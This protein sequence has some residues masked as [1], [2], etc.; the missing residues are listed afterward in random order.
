M[1]QLG[2]RIAAPLFLLLLTA[3]FFWR[4]T[5]SPEYTWLEGDDIAFTGRPWL[6]MQAREIHAGRFPLW[7][8]YEWGGQSVIGQVQPGITNPL[9]WILFA[10]PLREGHLPIGVLHWYWVLIRWLA[11]LACYALCRELK[12]GVAA[13]ALGASIY[14]LTGLIGHTD[15]PYLVMPAI[16]LPVALLGFTRMFRGE[17]PRSGAALCGLAMGMA[18]L[19]GHHQIPVDFT[20]VL[21]ALWLWFL[22][23]RGRQRE[24][25]I[26]AGVFAAIWLLVGAFQTLPALEYGRHSV[27]WANA[28]EPLRWQDKVPWSVHETYSFDW[29]LF[30]G[31]VMPRLRSFYMNPFVGFTAAAL[32]LSGL[33]LVRRSRDARL[34]AAVTLGGLVLALG[35]NTPV[36]RPLYDWVPL[37]E[38]ARTPAMAIV[39]AQLG[40]AALAAMA[41]QAWTAKRLAIG[42]IA[43]A[44]AVAEM[45]NAAPHFARFDRPDS[46]VKMMR[47]QSDI[48]GFLRKQPGWFRVRASEE[49]VPYNLG[50]FFGIE[51]FGGYVASMPENILKAQGRVEAARWFGIQYRIGRTPANTAE[52]EVFQSRT[53]LKVYRDPRIAEPVWFAHEAAC[54]AP[55]RFRVERRWPGGMDLQVSLPCPGEVIVGDPYFKGWKAWVDGRPAKISES[56]HIVRAVRVEAGNHR[57]EYRYRP[58]LVYWGGIASLLGVALAVWVWR[59]ESSRMQSCGVR[60]HTKSAPPV[61]GEF[62]R[63]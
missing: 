29:R 27:R 11:T 31:L 1:K 19:G 48:A 13:S 39:I 18:F 4:L 44:L 37:V 20:L 2:L 22:A 32:A 60:Q 45:V 35:T 50:D 47:E 62:Y 56:E 51:Q 36:Y 15:W 17:R 24:A 63:S 5:I 30:A 54:G 40:I 57:I 41:L 34:F 23:R 7:T 8:P 49:D 16:W 53:G 25:W 59:R 58:A 43:V 9:N 3:G 12:A 52:V 6:D 46:H 28:P 26:C 10:M 21:G 38:K 55:D 14:A 42:W 61:A 33:W